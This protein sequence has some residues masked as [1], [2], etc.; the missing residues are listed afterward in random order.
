[1]FLKEK[2]CGTIKGRRCAD[3]R[4]QRLYTGKDE[5][6]SKTVTIESVMLT[7]M[8]DAMEQRDIA[9]V[10]VPGVFLQ[11]DMDEVVYMV[12]RGKLVDAL[13]QYNPSK[14]EKFVVYNKGIKVIYVQLKK[15]L[16][17]TLRASLFIWEEL[18]WSP[19]R[20]GF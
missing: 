17:G 12:I 2:R 9:T 6:S 11:T 15:A 3:G 20:V 18:N 19:K 4:P 14:Y 10:D 1:M 8:V 13:V 16:Y 7:S 5:S